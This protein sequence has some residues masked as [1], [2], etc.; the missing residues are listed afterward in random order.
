VLFVFWSW[1]REE[2]LSKR[3]NDSEEYIRTKLSD[4]TERSIATMDENT[5]AY[6]QV[7]SLVTELSKSVRV[8]AEDRVCKYA[9]SRDDEK[10]P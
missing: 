9:V 1:K 8:L 2:R 10:A 5:V 3:V 4:M 6:K 7:T